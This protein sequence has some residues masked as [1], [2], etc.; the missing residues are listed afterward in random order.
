MEIIVM[1]WIHVILIV[2]HSTVK[3]LFL[4]DKHQQYNISAVCDSQSYIS[5][6]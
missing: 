3:F 1:Q 4:I 6:N 2:Y 5:V